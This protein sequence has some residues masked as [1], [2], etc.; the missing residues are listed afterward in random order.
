[1]KKSYEISFQGFF[2]EQ[3]FCRFLSFK[4]D[5][6]ETPRINEFSES[7]YCLTYFISNIKI[8]AENSF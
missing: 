3:L 8:H 5:N 4:T 1:M 2:N 7:L 6:H